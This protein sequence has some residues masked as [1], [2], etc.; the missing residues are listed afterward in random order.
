MRNSGRIRVTRVEA[1]FLHELFGETRHRLVVRR[2]DAKN[3]GEDL[4]EFQL[5]ISVVTRLQQELERAEQDMDESW[6]TSG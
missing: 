3:R 1:E 5:K 4:A 2:A 6:M